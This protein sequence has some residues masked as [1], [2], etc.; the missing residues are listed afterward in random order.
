MQRKANP[1]ANPR[2]QAD[3]RGCRASIR[4]TLCRTDSGRT[5][6]QRGIR[7]MGFPLCP[8][9]RTVDARGCDCAGK[10]RDG[11]WKAREFMDQN[12]LA[13]NK[14]PFDNSRTR[15]PRRIIS[16]RATFAARFAATCADS[17]RAFPGFVRLF[18]A[19]QRCESESARRREN[20]GRFLVFTKKRKGDV[21]TRGKG[22]FR[23]LAGIRVSNVSH[24]GG[25]TG[26][27]AS[28]LRGMQAHGPQFLFFP[29]RHLRQLHE[30]G[31]RIFFRAAE[32]V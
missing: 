18:H 29:V 31:L 2:K 32:R 8:I 12:R 1:R 17:N 27:A 23:P 25:G 13:G 9:G 5:G 4:W 28:R 11:G 16:A 30:K 3:R 19:K 6:M 15:K 21:R 24:S 7:Q 26:R 14:E 22:I 20:N 10:E